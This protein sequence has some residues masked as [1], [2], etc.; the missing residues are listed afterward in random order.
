MCVECSWRFCAWVSQEVRFSSQSSLYEHVSMQDGVRCG[1][2]PKIATLVS[3][4]VCRA[5]GQLTAK[6]GRSA[7]LLPVRAHPYRSMSTLTLTPHCRAAIGW[8]IGLVPM[9]ICSSSGA[10][11]CPNGNPS[12]HPPQLL[13]RS[14]TFRLTPH[15]TTANTHAQRPCSECE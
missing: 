7:R 6:D 5:R 4:Q 10:T 3:Q 13:T 15:L 11:T 8:L 14:K 12:L 2:S 9:W 1:T